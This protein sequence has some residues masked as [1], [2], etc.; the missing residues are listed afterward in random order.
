MISSRAPS[1]DTV[2]DRMQTRRPQASWRRTEANSK[3]SRAFGWSMITTSMPAWSWKRARPASML[4]TRCTCSSP[5]DRKTAFMMA[6][7]TGWGEMYSIW[8]F[9]YRSR[10][11]CSRVGRLDADAGM[12]CGGW[13]KDMQPARSPLEGRGSGTRSEVR[14]LNRNTPSWVILGDSALLMPRPRL[15]TLRCRPAPHGV[16]WPVLL[17][18]RARP[19]CR[20]WV[21][22]ELVSVLSLGLRLMVLSPR[23]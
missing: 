18:L 16:L 21:D 19:V 2:S 3:H 11:I 22:T 1:S 7:F 14:G 23:T 9:R 10:S 13:P 20:L 4:L 17:C 12:A 6:W 15:R 8:M 5:T